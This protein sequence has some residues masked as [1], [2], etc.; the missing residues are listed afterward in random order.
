M[1]SYPDIAYLIFT[2]PCTS[3]KF[4]YNDNGYKYYDCSWCL[5]ATM[6]IISLDLLYEY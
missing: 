4:T 6:I 1:Y 5:S 3:C 2:M